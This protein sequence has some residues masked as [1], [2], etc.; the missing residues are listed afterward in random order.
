VLA[1]VEDQLDLSRIFAKFLGLAPA[2][3]GERRSPR[4]RFQR[5][6]ERLLRVRVFALRKR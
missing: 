1:R 6:L 5:A 3:V 2:L 4:R